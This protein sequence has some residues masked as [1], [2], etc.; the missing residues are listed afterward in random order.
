LRRYLAGEL[1][2]LVGGVT[3]RGDHDDDLV[4][5]VVRLDDPFGYLLDPLGA[6]HG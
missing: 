1:E 6:V 3:H 2:Q 4:A 5:A